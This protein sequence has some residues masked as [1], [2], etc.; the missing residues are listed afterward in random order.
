MVEQD[1]VF[2]FEQSKLLKEQYASVHKHI[3][4]QQLGLGLTLAKAD[5][6]F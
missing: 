3:Q 4:S 5:G 6:M 1:E 2:I